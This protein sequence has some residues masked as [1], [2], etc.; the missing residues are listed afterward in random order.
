VTGVLMIAIYYWLRSIGIPTEEL[1]TVM[2]VSLSL[3]AIFF[4][5]SLKSLDTPVWRVNI[6]S[7]GYLLFALGTSVCLLLL[8]LVWPPLMHLLSLVPLTTF[9]KLLLVGVGLANLATI[10]AMKW[11]F[12]E[13]KL[14]PTPPA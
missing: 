3:D 12:F 13:R 6:F 4:S 5:F 11:L 1:R 14:P 9:E 10:E 7:N 8:S 2:F